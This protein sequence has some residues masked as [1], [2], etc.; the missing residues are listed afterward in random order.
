MF[1]LLRHWTLGSK[2]THRRASYRVGPFLGIALGRG[3]HVPFEKLLRPEKNTPAPRRS[4]S[5]GSVPSPE[6]RDREVI[7]VVAERDLAQRL[8]RC[9]ALQ[10]LAPDA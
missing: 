5:P 3:A 9:H 4:K 10:G 2:N 1:R 7:N 8:A 6:P